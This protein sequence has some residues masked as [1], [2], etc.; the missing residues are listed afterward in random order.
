MWGRD[1]RNQSI[2]AIVV[3]SLIGVLFYTSGTY[4][5]D[6]AWGTYH[7]ER[8]SNPFTLLV[9]DSVTG[10]WQFEL[11]IGLDE[12]DE[13][14]KSSVLRLSIDSDSANDTTRPGSANGAG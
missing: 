12:W 10:D 4:A 14:N 13:L 8:S 5:D 11:N 2:K 1:M 9:V 7:W 6:H 3:S